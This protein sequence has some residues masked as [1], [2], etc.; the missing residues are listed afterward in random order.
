V[1]H[2]ILDSSAESKRGKSGFNLGSTRT[3]LPC[4][5]GVSA[6]VHSP[7]NASAW[8]SRS[9]IFKTDL[10]TPEAADAGTP[11]AA[12]REPTRAA[13]FFCA[14]AAAAASFSAAAAAA[15]SAAALVVGTDE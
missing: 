7:P 6:G 10:I 12:A 11:M 9:G 2:H 5:L 4:P 8:S 13:A 1:I 15:F 14:A 3:A